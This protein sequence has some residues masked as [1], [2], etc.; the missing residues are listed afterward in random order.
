MHLNSWVRLIHRWVSILFTLT[1]IG[2]LIAALLRDQPIWVVL[3][4][5]PLLFLL[6][7]TGL[8]MFVL[9][10]ATKRRRATP[11]DPG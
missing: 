6:M 7:F 8:Y 5:L 11:G 9:P 10:Y 3:S 2:N 4:P 1:I